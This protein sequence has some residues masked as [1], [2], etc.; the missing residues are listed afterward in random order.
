M[1]FGSCCQRKIYISAAKFD[2]FANRN[3]ISTRYYFVLF[4]KAICTLIILRIWMFTIIVDLFVTF[5][6]LA[7]EI[8]TT[9]HCYKTN[10][11][12]L[13]TVFHLYIKYFMHKLA[14]GILS[15]NKGDS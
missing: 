6:N 1:R 9:L 7:F 5:Q 10:N 13:P 2:N 15:L 3:S 11:Y 8:K 4:L 14:I 12:K